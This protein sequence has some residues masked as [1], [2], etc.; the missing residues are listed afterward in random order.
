[1]KEKKGSSHLL[2]SPF[3]CFLLQFLLILPDSDLSSYAAYMFQYVV[4]IAR[5]CHFHSCVVADIVVAHV[6]AAHAVV[7]Y[8]VVAYAIVAH[9]FVITTLA[10]RFSHCCH[11]R[12]RYHYQNFHGHEKDPNP[13]TQIFA[14]SKK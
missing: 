7:A 8:A 2:F 1:M 13:I 4:S 6:V 3:L 9:L 12:Y 11:H 10:T 5:C 14:G